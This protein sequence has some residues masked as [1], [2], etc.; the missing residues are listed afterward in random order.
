MVDRCGVGHAPILGDLGDGEFIGVAEKE[1]RDPDGG[2]AHNPYVQAITQRW[3][4]ES[5]TG[6]R[7]WRNQTTLQT[8]A[9]VGSRTEN[10]TALPVHPLD[11]F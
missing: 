9:H 4:I 7:Y 5:G 3:Y 10:C 2:Y 1:L 11:G 8:F 6:G